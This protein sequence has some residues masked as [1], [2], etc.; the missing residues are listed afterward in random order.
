L[1]EQVKAKVLACVVGGV[2]VAV[3]VAFAYWVLQV[4]GSL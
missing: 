3:A 1:R 4:L 2:G